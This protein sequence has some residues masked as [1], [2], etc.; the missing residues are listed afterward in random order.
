ME[1]EL[2]PDEIERRMNAAVRKALHTAPQPRTAKPAKAP[3]KA[4]GAAA[5]KRGKR[6]PTG[7][8]S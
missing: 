3:A 7:G 5:A 2:P 6:A 4:K 8:E 1:Q